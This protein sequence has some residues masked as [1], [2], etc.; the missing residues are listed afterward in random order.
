[1]GEE[2][3][4]VTNSGARIL[5]RFHQARFHFLREYYWVE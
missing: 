1:M 3:S 5:I 4:K 2:P